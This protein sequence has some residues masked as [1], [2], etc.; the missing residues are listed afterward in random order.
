MKK[1]TLN[2][3]IVT[4]NNL[5]SNQQKSI[6]SLKQF[7]IL[8]MFSFSLVS[9][10]AQNRNSTTPNVLDVDAYIG[11]LK[12]TNKSNLRTKVIESTPQYVEN[13]VFG[14]NPAIYYQSGISKNYGENPVKLFTDITSLKTIPNSNL[15]KDDLE[16]VVIKIDN[17]TDLNNKIDLLKFSDFPKLKFI[18]ILSGINTTQ[19][20]I[21]N[22]FLNYTNQYSIFYKIE[23][24][25]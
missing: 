10:S 20:T 3:I 22:M 24:G 23:I 8:L 5:S 12:V 16:I 25:Q 6:F 1:S 2:K 7:L 19:Q 14:V 9:I 18:Y 4:N 21:S 13:L 15:S 11:S 17:S